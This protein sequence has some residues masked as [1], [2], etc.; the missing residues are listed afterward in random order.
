MEQRGVGG[1]RASDDGESQESV[2][3]N[4]GKQRRK[5]VERSVNVFIF[6]PFDAVF[7]E[8]KKVGG[9]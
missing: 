8:T 2:E 3:A 1:K 6:G 4:S 5:R 9:R 7:G